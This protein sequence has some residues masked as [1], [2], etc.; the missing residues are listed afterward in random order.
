[1]SVVRSARA[2]WKLSEQTNADYFVLRI[3]SREY[4]VAVLMHFVRREHANTAAAR[5]AG[6]RAYD[7][8]SRVRLN[9]VT[10]GR[11]SRRWRARARAHRRTVCVCVRVCARALFTTQ[12]AL[13]ADFSLLAKSKPS[14]L[15]RAHIAHVRIRARE[16]RRART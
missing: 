16:K 1:M 3:V 2:W 13:T 8:S 11:G 15:G 6:I 7:E 10:V 14:V 4:S 12:H 5:R 9:V